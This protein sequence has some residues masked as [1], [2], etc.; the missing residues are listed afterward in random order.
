MRGHMSVSIKNLRVSLGG[1]PVLNDL[2]LAFPAGQVT[3][4]IGPNGCG[5]TT[6]LRAIAGLQAAE[7][8]QV[9]WQQQPV[10]AMRPGQ[11]A[12]HIAILPQSAQVPDHMTVAEL[13]ARGRTPHLRP[14][15]PLSGRDKQAVQQAMRSVGIEDLAAR[16]VSAL[17]GGQ[18]Q[19]AWI[20]M[21]LAQDTPLVLLDEPTTF[22]DLPHQI[23]ILRL[24]ADL[25][26]THGKTIIAVLHDLNLAAR[27]CGHLAALRAGTLITAGPPAQVVTEE[28]IRRMFGIPC[29]IQSDRR[30]NTPVVLPA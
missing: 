19:R 27:F 17:S 23:D 15:R 7:G 6:L 8:G 2:T 20:A 30:Y 13:A 24:V 10:A 21:V 12:R 1:R 14:F 9:T 16:P 5:K 4:L 11:R 26:R 18:R 3:G 22:L 28:T 25:S 29:Q